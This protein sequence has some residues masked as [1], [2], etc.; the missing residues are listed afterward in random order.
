MEYNSACTD[1]ILTLKGSNYN[2]NQNSNKFSKKQFV[3]KTEC[4]EKPSSAQRSGSTQRA[5]TPTQSRQTSSAPKR[6]TFTR[7]T[8]TA[9]QT[10]SKTPTSK[11]GTASQKAQS[12]TSTTKTNAPVRTSSTNQT[13]KTQPTS[14][15]NSKR[16]DSFEFSSKDVEKSVRSG[17]N[18][19]STTNGKSTTKNNNQ[20]SMN[21][22]TK[23]TVKSNSSNK[24][25]VLGSASKSNKSSKNKVPEGLK[26]HLQHTSDTKQKAGM[27]KTAEDYAAGKVVDQ[28]SQKLK[29]L[30]IDISKLH[31]GLNSQ[32]KEAKLVTDAQIYE[33]TADNNSGTEKEGFITQT[34]Y[35]RMLYIIT[36]ENGTTQNAST[37]MFATASALLNSFEA[38]DY[39]A[40]YGSMSSKLS[41]FES[42]NEGHGLFDANNG[43]APEVQELGHQVLDIVLS[44]VRID[45]INCWTGDG[46][47]AFFS[48]TWDEDWRKNSAAFK[49]GLI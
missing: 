29:E 49:A 28:K 2:G 45:G 39:Y 13:K 14:S 47:T 40:K 9:K 38:Q 22:Q 43:S 1:I 33:L 27:R 16:R 26:Q 42:N 19:K 44:G 11:T 34:E 23:K 24:N 7:S 31:F 32:I 35:D 10:P 3:F 6:D 17:T 5:S 48:S 20:N 8:P 4:T 30:G 18:S 37:D 46:S 25:T 41:A 15:K 12:K 36:H 21:G